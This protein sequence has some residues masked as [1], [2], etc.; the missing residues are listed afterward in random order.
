M[1]VG[2]VVSSIRMNVHGV[3]RSNDLT[4]AKAYTLAVSA[5]NLA[6]C[7]TKAVGSLPTVAMRMSSVLVTTLGVDS[8][9]AIC[10]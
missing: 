2:T 9:V 4:A 7:S 1:N 6:G 8:C 3:V 10:Y 5:L